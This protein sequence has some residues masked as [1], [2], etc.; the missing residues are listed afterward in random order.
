MLDRVEAGEELLIAR[1]GTP[2]SRMIPVANKGEEAATRF[3]R[4][5][6]R[7]R[8]GLRRRGVVAK[9]GELLRWRDEGRR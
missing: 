5:A 7:V 8:N 1:H 2:V 3:L 6:K 9:P 4:E